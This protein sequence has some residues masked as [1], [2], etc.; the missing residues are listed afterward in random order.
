[1]TGRTGFTTSATVSNTYTIASTEAASPATATPTFSVAPGAYSAA[2]T[3]SLASATSG[4]AIY[5]T[6]DGSTPTTASAKYS[7]AIR[8]AATETLSAMATAANHTASPVAKAAYVISVPAMPGFTTSELQLH[9]SAA[10]VGTTLRLT[11]GA[12]AQSAVAWSN[13]PVPVS[14]FTADFTFQLPTSTADGFTFTIQNAPAGTWA[15]GSNAG[16]FGYSGISNSVA[17][18][19]G[20][21]SDATNSMVSQTGLLEN[22]QSTSAQSIDMSSNL[23]LHAG[24]LYSVH[25]VYAGTT[26]AETVTDTNT[27]GVFTHSYSVNIPS[28]V[29]GSSAYV[30]FTGSTGGFTSVQNLLTWGWASQA[31]TTTVAA[32]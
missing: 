27:G 32:K 22:G 6:V 21:Y 10:I 26:L 30:G 23:S 11:S 1:M 24:H 28:I 20:L 17:I 25:L 5:Y 2:Q 29:G 31:A 12:P 7:G 3:V 18:K 4:A 14:A 9:G 19:F 8:V 15:I 16:G 13:A